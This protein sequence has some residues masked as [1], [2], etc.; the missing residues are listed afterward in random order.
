MSVLVCIAFTVSF[1][2]FSQGNHE[3]NLEIQAEFDKALS[4]VNESQKL[5]NSS[6]ISFYLMQEAAKNENPLALAWLKNEAHNHSIGAL[7]SLGYY[8]G[9]KKESANAIANFKK[10]ADLGSQDALSVMAS[11][12][13][14]GW[15]G[16]AKNEK[17]GCEWSKKSAEAGN[18]RDAVE[19]SLCV[20][21]PMI[22][23]T[24]D[25]DES[26][27]WGEIGANGMTSELKSVQKFLKEN[28]IDTLN[29][30]WV[31]GVRT[32][33]GRSYVLFALCL[34]ENSK[35]KHRLHEAASLY[36]QAYEL[37]NKY[38]GLLYGTMLENGRGVVQDYEEA[39][40]WYKITAESGLPEAQNRL[41]AK[42]AEGK[43]VGKNLIE[44]MKWFI[45]SSANGYDGA[46][47][48]RDKAEKMLSAIEVKRAQSLAS[49]WMR[50]FK[51]Q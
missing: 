11:I 12:Y 7:I 26:C 44:A 6:Q 1:S 50:K 48:N 20:G 22:G 24:R 39:F 46:Q 18:H 4:W 40:R 19:Y 27:K 8:Y 49:E 37:G 3:S 17:I 16:T 9:A 28:K 51:G 45:I 15:Y 34:Q 29:N 13:S 2:A 41:G 31:T 32:S 35:M 21:L 47:D 43:G 5:G 42:Y 14:E 10:A 36:K 23:I 33:T 30:D 38:A 25:L